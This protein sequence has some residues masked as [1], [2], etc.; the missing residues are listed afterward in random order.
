MP[1]DCAHFVKTGRSWVE[2]VM[3]SEVEPSN[4]RARVFFLRYMQVK[5]LYFG[6]LKDMVGHRSS[7]MEL[8]EGLSVAE[9][10]KLH[11]AKLES[12]AGFW[13]SIAVAVNQQYAKAEDVLHDGDEVALLPPVSGGLR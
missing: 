1:L 3:F 8:P 13:S 6:V 4:R 2:V 12:S 10:V 11:E 5:V 7:E 9:L